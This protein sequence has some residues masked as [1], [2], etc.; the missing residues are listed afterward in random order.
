[1]FRRPA[2]RG[3][4]RCALWWKAA[5]RG[6]ASRDAEVLRYANGN[7]DVVHP[8]DAHELLSTAAFLGDLPQHFYVVGVEPSDVHH[9][10]TSGEMRKGLESATVQAQEIIDR[11]LV[12]LSEPAYA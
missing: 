8:G 12:E 1:M 4:S 3:G 10:D 11:W 7:A 5:R 9:G 2:D 6:P